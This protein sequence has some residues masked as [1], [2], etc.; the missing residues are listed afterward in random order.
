MSHT[1]KTHLF[2][3]IGLIG[4]CSWLCIASWAA[5]AQ[6]T[7]VEEVL[8]PDS[9]MEQERAF[10]RSLN[11]SA[12]KIMSWY[13]SLLKADA[14]TKSTSQRNEFLSLKKQWDDYRSNHYPGKTLSIELNDTNTPEKK[15]NGAHV[16]TLSGRYFYEDDEGLHAFSFKE[17]FVF[18]VASNGMPRLV[19]VERTQSNK[20]NAVDAAGSTEGYVRADFA[21]RAFAY[22]WAAWL[23]GANSARSYLESRGLASD[24]L[25]R[26]ELGGK[27]HEGQASEMRQQRFQ[28]LGI[29]AHR[30]K[31]VRRI[32]AETDNDSAPPAK[33]V[34]TF[35]W[36]GTREDGRSAIAK[37]RQTIH[38]KRSS[39]SDA[40]EIPLI[41]EEHLLPNLNPW[42][43]WLC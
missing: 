13:G 34:L 35:R 22:A 24:T 26:V 33:L 23:D 7:A 16:F 2:H 6:A 1:K 15:A 19:K 31:S 21:A 9:P 12:A 14:Q 38:F 8:A 18:E 10:Q 29:G 40:P 43:S 30:L 17:R 5:V 3:K 36:E 20:P 41:T 4:L 27:K 28:F 37:I 42:Q 25:H 39:K 11:L 32:P